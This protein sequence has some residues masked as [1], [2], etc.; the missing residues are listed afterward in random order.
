[1]FTKR[2]LRKI[3][4]PMSVA[5]REDWTKLQIE[6]LHGLYFSPHINAVIKSRRMR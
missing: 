4:E 6:Q 2:V 5:F 3:S 1:V